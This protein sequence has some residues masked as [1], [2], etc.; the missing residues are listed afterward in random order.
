MKRVLC[1]ALLAVAAFSA[2]PAQAAAP[3][4]SDFVRV[5]NNQYGTGVGTGIP[6][7]PLV[8]VWTDNIHDELCVG[9]SEMVPQCVPFSTD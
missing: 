4:L 1:G 9:V 3:D 8:G 7:Q 6:G 5:W 2:V